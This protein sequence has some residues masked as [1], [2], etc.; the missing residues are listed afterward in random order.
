MN[1]TIYYLINVPRTL[2]SVGITM[3]TCDDCNE[4][5]TML[6]CDVCSGLNYN[7]QMCAKSF[8]LFAE[9]Y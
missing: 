9:I 4:L 1:A 7:A 8:L 3:H 5:I 2:T 6:K